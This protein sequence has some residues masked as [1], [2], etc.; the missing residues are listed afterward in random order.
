MTCE[1]VFLKPALKC[2]SGFILQMFYIGH[3][4]DITEK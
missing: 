3:K 1:L 4:S 2:S